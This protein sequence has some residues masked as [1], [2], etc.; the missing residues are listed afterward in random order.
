MRKNRSNNIALGREGETIAASFIEN[1]GFEIL[2]KNYRYKNIGE[3]DIIAKKD[4]LIVFFEVKTRK[5]LSYGGGLFSINERKKLTL[6]KTASHFLTEY[7]DLYKKEITYRF[8]L[9]SI[10][11]GRIDLIEDFIR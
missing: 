9:I 7:P 6:R 4:N 5:K 3:I 8:D 1:N 2:K 10:H 11:E